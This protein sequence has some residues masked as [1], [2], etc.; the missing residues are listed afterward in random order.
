MTEHEHKVRCLTDWGSGG[1]LTRI[2]RTI[3]IT[4]DEA[5]L[6]NIFSGTW[7][8]WTETQ[9]VLGRYVRLEKLG[10][11]TTIRAKTMRVSCVDRLTFI[12]PLMVEVTDSLSCSVTCLFLATIH[13][14]VPT[15]SK[16]RI[17]T[18]MTGGRRLLSCY[19][20]L[21]M[22]RSFGCATESRLGYGCGRICPLKL[23]VC[24]SETGSNHTNEIFEVKFVL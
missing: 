1:S 15:L 23:S 11:G 18:K 13:I 7:W 9:I 3:Q 2:L 22:R 4:M 17:R 8:L 20:P 10:I 16:S 24:V 6:L 5:S 21:H 12:L 14:N 19:L